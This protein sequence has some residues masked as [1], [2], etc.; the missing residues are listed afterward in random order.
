MIKSNYLSLNN[1][2]SCVNLYLIVFI[3][4]VICFHECCA[5]NEKTN[6]K[7]NLR[8]PNTKNDEFIDFSYSNQDYINYVTYSGECFFIL[9]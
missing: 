8:S 9:S 7:R 2:K 6:L 1:R 5:H 4:I 3:Y